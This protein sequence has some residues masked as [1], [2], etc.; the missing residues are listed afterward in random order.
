MNFRL[1]FPHGLE[2]E[3]NECKRWLY[4]MGI[5]ITG[6]LHGEIG[7]K[8]LSFN[9]WPES[10]DL[11]REDVLI[12]TGDFG[13]PFW[14]TETFTL[15]NDMRQYEKGDNKIYHYWIQ[16]LSERPYTILFVDGN[17]ECVP[18]WNKQ[19]ESILFGGR[20]Q[21][22]PDAANVYHLCRGEYYTIQDRTFWVMGG[23]NSFDKEWRTEG[24]NWWKEEIPSITEM[25]HGLNTLA[26]HDN[27]V[28]YI[29]THTMPQKLIEPVL[30]V[31]Y[32]SEP[33]QS[34]LDT[35]YDRAQ[36]KEWFC[37]HF[38]RDLTDIDY[39]IHV[40][41]NTITKVGVYC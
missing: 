12:I 22:H 1:K 35:V 41:Y 11:T 15:N 21:Q 25:E 6:D 28:D 9:N 10:R 29:V 33:T 17:H 14:P 38:H 18:Y 5:Y 24:V 13:L 34:Y 16:W 20:V 40:L 3:N 39:N 23:A 36:F 30:G 19:P 7:I 31:G 8:K 26:A 27:K 4:N 32:E 2:T 37:G